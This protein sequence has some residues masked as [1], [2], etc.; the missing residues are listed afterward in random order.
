MDCIEMYEKRRLLD[1]FN[2]PE[3]PRGMSSDVCSAFF[4]PQKGKKKNSS[5]TEAVADVH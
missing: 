1:I 5:K 4:H 2:I 3:S